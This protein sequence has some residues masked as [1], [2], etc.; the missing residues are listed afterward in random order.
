MKITLKDGRKIF[1]EFKYV[2]VQKHLIGTAALLEIID[3]KGMLS[4]YKATAIVHPDE[5][6]SRMVGRK[7]A[8]R[9]ALKKAKFK[10]AIRTEIWELI[11]K[12]GMKLFSKKSVAVSRS[13]MGKI[14][15]ALS[16][17]HERL[18][19][20]DPNDEDVHKGIGDEAEWGVAIEKKE[21]HEAMK[22]VKS[23]MKEV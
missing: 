15:E 17:A 23:L 2:Y 16:T 22:L 8:L 4:K 21:V 6:A 20:I 19:C 11:T 9:Y 13:D 3:L 1:I 10:Q 5:P 14:Y 7:I 12:Q 18:D